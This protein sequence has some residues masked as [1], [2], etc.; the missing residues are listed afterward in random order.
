MDVESTCICM[1]IECPQNA[2][3]DTCV[4]VLCML[5]QPD[6]HVESI[7][8]RVLIECPKNDTGTRVLLMLCVE[9]THAV[10]H[11]LE[12]HRHWATRVHP[13]LNSGTFD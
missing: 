2:T 1:L 7:C 11:T 12:Q 10:K 8:I 9:M 13:V 6:I 3:Q 4:L 5:N